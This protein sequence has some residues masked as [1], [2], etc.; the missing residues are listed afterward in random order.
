MLKRLGHDGRRTSVVCGLAAIVVLGLACHG[1]D[2]Q[3]PGPSAGD[4]L[5]LDRQVTFEVDANARKVHVEPAV[6]LQ[7]TGGGVTFL[8]KGL[9]EGYTLEIDF[10]TEGGTRGPFPKGPGALARGRYTLSAKAPS[11]PS[12]SSEAT[13]AGVWKYEVVLRDAK[14]DDLVAIDPMGVLK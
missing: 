14:G 3:S 2:A 9:P 10:K 13:A 11:L 7:R 4:P 8:A 6:F 12:G 1:S 5:P